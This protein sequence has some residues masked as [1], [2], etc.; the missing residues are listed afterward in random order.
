MDFMWR[1][2]WKDSNIRS[3]TVNSFSLFQFYLILDRLD[4]IQE[5]DCFRYTLG[6][7][8]S[9][10]QQAAIIKGQQQS[11]RTIRSSSIDES[12]SDVKVLSLAVSRKGDSLTVIL[13]DGRLLLY[14][15]PN[16]L[17]P[18][19]FEGLFSSMDDALDKDSD[20]KT[21][22][23]SLLSLAGFGKNLLKLGTKSIQK[24]KNLV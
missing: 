6:P 8:S 13:S 14:V 22:S 20:S 18:A 12:Q 11:S 21:D 9:R 24:I 2:I 10:A 3:I 5:I 23:S 19:Q 1:C 7:K 16:L 15:L 17:T 4:V